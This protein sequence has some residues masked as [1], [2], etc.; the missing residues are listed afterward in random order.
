MAYTEKQFK[1]LPQWAQ[2]ELIIRQRN[3]EYWEGE[4]KLVETEQS[5]ITVKYTGDSKEVFIPSKCHIR[6]RF[7]DYW[8]DSI[9]VYSQEQ[10][11]GINRERTKV[12]HVTA[13]QGG[14]HILPV[15]TNVV[16]IY[17]K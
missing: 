11:I 7:G 4:C 8:S 5:D 10:Y 13:N 12:L 17:Q 3:A 16:D 2:T 14:L 6:F 9:D 15:S 1:A